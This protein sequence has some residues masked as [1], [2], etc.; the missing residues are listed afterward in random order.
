MCPL[1]L[2]MVCGQLDCYLFVVDLEVGDLDTEGPRPLPLDTGSA[3]G[4][5]CD[6][7]EEVVDGQGDHTRTLGGTLERQ[8]QKK[9][10]VSQ[11]MPREGKGREATVNDSLGGCGG[12]RT[13][14]V[15]VLP[16]AVCP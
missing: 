4:G 15:Y 16:V 5:V 6:L 11:G 1:N 2:M 3:G 14:S 10:G 7:V 8:R 9:E 12:V 13:C